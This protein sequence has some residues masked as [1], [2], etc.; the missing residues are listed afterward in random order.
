MIVH[1]KNVLAI[2]VGRERHV[3]GSFRM[4]R[5]LSSLSMHALFALASCE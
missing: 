2:G 4:L 3:D 1:G 5:K